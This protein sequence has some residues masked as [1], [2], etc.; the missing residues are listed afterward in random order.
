MNLF[1]ATAFLAAAAILHAEPV[2]LSGIYPGLAT[3]NEE[4]ECGTGA[5]VPW[6]DRLWVI[7]YAPHAPKGSS[8][9]LY[10]ITPDLQQI[11]R[12]ESIGGTPANRMIH[13]ESQQLF[14]GP[15]AIAADQQVRTIPYSAMYGRPTGNARHL[16]EASNKI[17]YATMEEGIYEVDVKTLAVTELWR[18]EQL[19]GGRKAGL[20]GYHGK[21]LYSGQGRLIYANNGDHSGESATNPEIPSGVLAE[22]DGKAAAWTVVRRNQ[23]T[24][25]T[26]PGGIEGNPSPATDPVWSIGWDYRSLI[27]ACLHEGAWH[28]WRLPK[29]SHSYDGSHGW[30]T[31]WPRIRDVGGKDYLMTMHGTFWKFPKTFTPAASAG[32]APRSNYLKV[33]GDFC[34]WNDRLVFGCDDTAKS[35]FINKRKAKGQITA[36]QSQSNLWFTTP[37]QLDQFGP[38]IGRGAVWSRDKVEPGKPSDAYLFSGYDR[39]G[40]HLTRSSAAKPA[41]ISI[42]IDEAG[43]G[44]WRKVREIALKETHQ[45]TDLSDLKGAWIRLVSDTTLENATAFFQYA[46]EDRRGDSPDAIFSGLAT[47]ADADVAGG[48]VRARA[49]NKRT[50]SLLSMSGKTELGG[51]ELDSDLK[52][53]K[54]GDA[55]LAAFTART[56]AIPQG[57]LARDEASVIYTDDKGKR[58]RLPEGTAKSASPLGDLRVCREVA[59]ER[60]LFHAAGTFYELPAENAGG[61][62]KARAI[63]SS[64]HLVHDFCSYRGLFI[65]TGIAAGQGTGNPHIIRSEDG[66]AALWAGAID[67]LWK[68]GKPRG[69]GG[70]WKSTPVKAGQ[71]SD[72]YLMTGFDR[73]S[74]ALSADH[75][76]TI[77]AEIDITGSGLW[78]PYQSFAVKDRLTHEFPAAFQAY[79]IRFTSDR[80]AKVDAQLS[81]R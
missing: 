28:F 73:K 49:E 43:I 59:T 24:E 65:M 63:A 13:K 53:R 14:I 7:T 57:V 75:P 3:F 1:L 72:P 20:P 33:V 17:Y 71:A 60:D 58:W 69:Q 46:N 52:L 26:G 4:G 36:P 34:R 8:D 76:A 79:W 6:A 78:V 39:K 22:W 29:G 32:I 40:L 48:L 80:D 12:S 37:E 10:E 31:E 11:V 45:W 55:S 56:T 9:K 25:V 27:L 66:Q 70:P 54:S 16:T 41:I 67:D 47:T 19:K 50:L 61:F 64:G 51:Y 77:T 42:E 23:F 62:A 21:G 38:V 15:Y 5:V 2:Q 81:Y 44:T 74:L 18:D 35:E 30:N 68:I